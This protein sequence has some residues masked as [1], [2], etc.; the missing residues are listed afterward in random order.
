MAAQCDVLAEHLGELAPE[1]EPTAAAETEDQSC[2]IRGLAD[3]AAG[4]AGDCCT[5]KKST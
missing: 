5:P 3:R 1:P 2:A 4:A